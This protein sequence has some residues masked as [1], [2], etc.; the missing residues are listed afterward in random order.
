V[1]EIET[2]ATI[3]RDM[4]QTRERLAETIDEL[5]YRT[6]PKTMVRREIDV[7]KG[8]FVDP[9]GNPRTENILK[10]VGGI[11]GVIGVLVV[12]RKVTH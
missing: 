4:E 2:P 8:Y 5:L 10:V 7:V 9:Q 11:A 6:N 3:E 12:I 1:S